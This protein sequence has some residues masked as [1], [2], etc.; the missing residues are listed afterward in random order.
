MFCNK[1]VCSEQLLMVMDMFIVIVMKMV[2]VTPMLGPTRLVGGMVLMVMVMVSRLVM[3]CGNGE[4]DG[5]NLPCWFYGC[6]VL[7]VVI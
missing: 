6:I 4:G 3:R 2:I 5:Q 7:A 1:K